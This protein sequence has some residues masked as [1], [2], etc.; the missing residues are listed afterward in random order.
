LIRN[1]WHLVLYYMAKFK[2]IFNRDKCIGCGTCVAV[3]PANWEIKD[4]GKSMPKETE[5]EEI[6]CSKMAEESC[7]V[8]AIKIEPVK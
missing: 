8:Q 3:C 2:V 4:D 5:L 6:G 7:P 1:D